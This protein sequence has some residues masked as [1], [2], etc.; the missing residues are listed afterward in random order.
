MNLGCLFSRVDNII[1]TRASGFFFVCVLFLYC[2]HYHVSVRPSATVMLKPLMTTKSTFYLLFLFS[3]F[4][5]VVSVIAPVRLSSLL[6]AS[7]LDDS[8]MLENPVAGDGKT[9]SNYKFP[10]SMQSVQN[11][12]SSSSHSSDLSPDVIS[13][14]FKAASS[15]SAKLKSIFSE[16]PKTLITSLPFIREQLIYSLKKK[17]GDDYD[18]KSPDQ[19]PEFIELNSDDSVRLLETAD[20]YYLGTDA[21]KLKLK[22]VSIRCKSTNSYLQFS[23]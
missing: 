12:L 20:S 1:Y 8:Q 13:A 17:F 14:I 6:L 2:Y 23:V 18:P 7:E 5:V 10:H 4:N 9:S 15:P 22:I 21:L 11:V 19:N 16:V 3:I